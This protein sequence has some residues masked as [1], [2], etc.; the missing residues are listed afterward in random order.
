MTAVGTSLMRAVGT[1]SQVRKGRVKA[2]KTPKSGSNVR[3]RLVYPAIVNDSVGRCVPKNAGRA[4]ET[5]YF[6]LFELARQG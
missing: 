3:N 2:S 6:K 1:L 4:S 5:I